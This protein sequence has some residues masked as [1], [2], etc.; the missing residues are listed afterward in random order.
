MRKQPY[1][2]PTCEEHKDPYL[3]N[4]KWWECGRDKQLLP[5]IYCLVLDEESIIDN[6]LTAEWVEIHETRGRHIFLEVSE[7]LYKKIIKTK[8]IK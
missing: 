4:G 2:N 1:N 7:D 5:K 3:W 6:D 8:K